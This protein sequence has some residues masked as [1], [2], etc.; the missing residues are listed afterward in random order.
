MKDDTTSSLRAVAHPVRLRIL[1]LLTGT[2][3]SAADVARELDV[4]HANASYHLRVLLDAGE[5]EIA[6]EEKIRGGVA[7]R[8]RHPW[9]SEALM[10]A[11]GTPEEAEQYLRAMAQELVRRYKHRRRGGAKSNL[12][13]AELWVPEEVYERVSA[14]VHEASVLLHGEA[15]PPRTEGTVPVAMTAA[16]FPLELDRPEGDR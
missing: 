10:H 3:L 6:S 8:Y 1:S 7:K 2:E 9:E 13:D 11:G 16:L 15:R 5:L 4:T 12:T 14:L